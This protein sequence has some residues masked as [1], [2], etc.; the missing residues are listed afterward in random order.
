MLFDKI[1]FRQPTC[2]WWFLFTFD[3]PFRKIYQ[4]PIKILTPYI[5][6]GDRVV[7]LGC[8]M[9]YFSIPM[10]KLVGESGKVIAIDMQEKM[11]SG[12]RR[13]AEKNRL[14]DRITTHQCTQDRISVS[15]QVDF[16]LAF[17]MVHE[18][19]N[20]RLFL[21]QIWTLLGSGGKLLI[22]EPYLHVP[23]NRFEEIK[24]EVI[25]AGFSIIGSPLIG[26]SRS[27]LAKKDNKNGN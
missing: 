20:S 24:S 17:W 8:G 10:A 7:D 22:A 9:G 12:L 1:K 26:F 16:A 2:P 19:H 11:L 27:L 5:N 23:K 25:E 18:V 13:R 4:D 3:N 14:I 21:N 15:E 6:N